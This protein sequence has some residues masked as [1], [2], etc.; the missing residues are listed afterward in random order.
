MVHQV[1]AREAGTPLETWSGTEP[2]AV[3]QDGYQGSGV[4]VDA[5]DD[6]DHGVMM[7]VMRE[8]A[9]GG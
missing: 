8:A 9:I 1:I 3:G 6:A 2:S 4:A 7:V 5:E